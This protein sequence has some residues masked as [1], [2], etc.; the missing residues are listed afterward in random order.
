MAMR[1]TGP[2]FT[3]I[4]LRT[5]IIITSYLLWDVAVA[6]TGHLGFLLGVIKGWKTEL[7]LPIWWLSKQSFRVVDEPLGSLNENNKN[8]L[9]NVVC[10]ADEFQSIKS[11]AGTW[12]DSCIFS[13]FLST[14][15]QIKCGVKYLEISIVRSSFPSSFNLRFCLVEYI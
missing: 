14:C 5:S 11:F 4:S 15:T 8:Q 6:K 1:S 9:P 10:T 7:K 3:L 13:T 2:D 12:L